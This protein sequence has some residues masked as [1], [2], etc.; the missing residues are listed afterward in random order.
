MNFYD[1]A[2]QEAFSNA[3]MKAHVSTTDRER[4]SLFYLLTLLPTTRE[5]LNDLYDFKYNHIR[6]LSI[7]EPWQTGSSTKLTYLAFNLYN[8]F[9]FREGV[10]LEDLE[11]APSKNTGNLIDFFDETIILEK[12]YSVLDIFATLDKDEIPFVFEAIQIRLGII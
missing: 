5:H 6:F 9:C 12:H 10:G 1:D 7:H 4:L 3:M 2:H 11:F 8:N